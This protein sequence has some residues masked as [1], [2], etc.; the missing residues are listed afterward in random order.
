MSADQQITQSQQHHSSEAQPTP[1]A[2]QRPPRVVV[3]I[4]TLVVV[5]FLVIN[6]VFFWMLVLGVQQGRA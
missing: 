4:G 5:G 6:I 3:P 1:G 2:P